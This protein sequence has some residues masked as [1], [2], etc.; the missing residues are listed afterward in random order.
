MRAC[1][2]ALL[3]LIPA[4]SALAGQAP[5][6]AE[7]PDIT[8]SAHDQFHTADQFSNT[9]IGDQ[10]RVSPGWASSSIPNTISASL[11]AD[12]SHATL[13]NERGQITRI[14]SA[15]YGLPLPTTT[16]RKNRA[17]RRSPRPV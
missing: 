15:S 12:T 16:W 13:S 8:L 9:V 5:G 10:P 14:A 6:S 3:M 1:L 2:S 4:L 11:T 17:G 7:Q